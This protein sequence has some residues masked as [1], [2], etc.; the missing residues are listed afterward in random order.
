MMVQIEYLVAAGLFS[1]LASAAPAPVL[2]LRQTNETVDVTFAD[3][4]PSPDLKWADCYKANFQCAFLT[5]PLDYANISAG[6]TD[7]AFLRYLISEDAQDLLFNP[8]ENVMIHF[9]RQQVTNKHTGGP[10]ESGTEF[11]L[12]SGPAMAKRWGYNPVSFDPRGV[13]WTKPK[14]SCSYDQNNST[15]SR[16]DN[17]DALGDMTEIWNVSFAQNHACAVAN[18]HTNAKYVG[19]SAVVQDLMYF[20]ELQAAARGKDPKKALINYYGVSYGTLLG[21]TL[22]AMYPDRIRRILLDGNVYGVAHYQGWEPTGLDD[23]AHGIWLF[24][25]L[26]FEAG[27]QWCSLA[28][29]AKS[30]EEVKARFDLAVEVLRLHPVNDPSGARV[31]DTTFLA[32]IQQLMYAP[33]SDEKGFAMLSNATVSVLTSNST[34]VKMMKRDNPTDTSSDAL[35]II[36]G[37]DIAGRYP[38]STYEQWKAAAEQLETTAPYGAKGYAGTNG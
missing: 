15:L 11:L 33:S 23:L 12:S 2:R 9:K 22:V 5:V 1:T 31:D 24:S 10:G 20:T 37:V 16:R 3:I 13:S 35:G 8:G 29:G 28:E 7:V 27:E 36:T 38:W 19:T 14:I 30:I 17:L 6:T 21:Q 25:K 26:C 18:E 32:T 4:V 34:N